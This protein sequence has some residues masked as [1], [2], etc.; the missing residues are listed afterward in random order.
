[1]A[2]INKY[3]RAE[4]IRGLD[5]DAYIYKY[6]RLG[7]LLSMLQGRKLRINK[8]KTWE[9]PY[10]N[11]FLKEGFFFASPEDKKNIQMHTDDVSERVYGQSW[12]LKEESDAMWR[13]YSNRKGNVEEKAV[14]IKVKVDS[15][16]SLVYT[17]DSCMATTSIGA[18]KYL[19]AEAFDGTRKELANCISVLNFGKVIEDCLYMKRDSFGHEEEVR[20]IISHDTAQEKEEFL[21]FDIPDIS[22]FEEYVLDPRLDDN[23]LAASIKLITECGVE[24]EKIRRSDLYDF[25][26]KPI[27]LGTN[28]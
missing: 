6:M 17:E 9:D 10:E 4:R 13:I 27:N 25:V 12:T 23:E 5:P 11:F 28:K 21:E 8:V 22:I 3:Y 14:K 2:E 1:M 24:E 19:T 20:I 26:P 15:L 7:Y 16:F 18:V